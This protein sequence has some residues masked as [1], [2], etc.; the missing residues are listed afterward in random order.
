MGSPCV[1]APPERAWHLVA[2]ASAVLL[3]H[4]C[5]PPWSE[6]R[7]ET[8]SMAPSLG[9]VSGVGAARA[10]GK[11]SGGTGALPRRGRP[12][13]ERGPD[14]SWRNFRCHGRHPRR[15]AAGWRAGTPTY[16]AWGRS[17]EPLPSTGDALVEM[18]GNGDGGQK[19]QN[20]SSYFREP[21]VSFMD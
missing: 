11:I 18:G 1:K 5:A 16:R 2:L 17:G 7:W 15:Q 3:F 13:D 4:C 8:C 14:L 20:S 10:G 9:S 12:G 21:Y 19:K 6:A